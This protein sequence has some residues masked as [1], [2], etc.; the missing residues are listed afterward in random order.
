MTAPLQ[1]QRG[2]C[3][4]VAAVP[5]MA[6]LERRE[7]CAGRG[8]ARAL[9]QRVWLSPGT[10]PSPATWAGRYLPGGVAA[11]VEGGGFKAPALT[12]PGEGG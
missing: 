12:L 8:G 11:G 5:E 2:K 1:T 10:G 9:A 3:R 6:A 7:G 4:R